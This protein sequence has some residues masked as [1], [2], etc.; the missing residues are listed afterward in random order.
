MKI[1]DFDEKENTGLFEGFSESNEIQRSEKKLDFVYNVELKDNIKFIDSFE[2]GSL[3]L[4]VTS[5]PYN[6]GKSYE[7]KTPLENYVESQKE[8]IQKCYDKLHPEG[9]ICWQ[10]GNNVNKGEIYPL[11]IILYPI[12]K[13]LGLKLRNRIVWHF[14][15]GLHCSN[16]LSGRYET[17]LWFTKSDNYTFNLDPIRVPSKYPNKKYFKGPK[18][19]QISGNPLGKNPGDLWIIP[20]VKSNHVEKTNHPCQFPIE[21]IERLVLSLTNEEDKVFD[22][23]MGVGSSVLAALL[24]NREGYGCDIESEY[25]KIAKQRINDLKHGRLKTRPMGKPV[26]DPSLPNGGHR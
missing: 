7:K 6:I 16:R 2:N 15:H 13:D 22:P 19:G 11:D 23:Y 25:V 9:S 26:Y 21:L 8:L 4:I 17:I 24:H 12:F 20:N 14:E 18:A 1:K 5:P 10:V 3:K